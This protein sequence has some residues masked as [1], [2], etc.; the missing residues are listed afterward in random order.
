MEKNITRELP[1]SLDCNGHLTMLDVCASDQLEI[2][3]VME[4]GFFDPIPENLKRCK[5]LIHVCIGKN[6][7]NGR[8]PPGLFNL[9]GVVWYT[10]FVE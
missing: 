3:V 8:V 9:L 5:S 6:F 2:L 10:K 7:L 4:N 1:R